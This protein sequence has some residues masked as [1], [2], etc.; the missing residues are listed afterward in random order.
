MLWTNERNG[1]KVMKIIHC[2]DLHLDSKMTAN[3]SKEQAKERKNEILRTFT[4]MVEYAKKNQVKVILIAGDLFDTRN[5]SAMV[6]NTVRDVIT[7]NPEIDFLY[8]KGN[9]DNDNF[10]SKLEEIPENLYLFGDEWTTYAY[11]NVRITGLELNAENSLTAYNSLVL[12]HDTFNIVTMHGQLSGY[13]N[14]DKTEIISL[15]DLKNKNIDYLALGHIHG[16]HMDKMD[17]RGIYCYP[18]CLEGRGFDECEQ[19]GFVVLD[20]NMDTLKANVNFVKMGYRTLYTMLVDVTGVS[21]TQEAA[22]RID[23]ALQENQYASSSLVKVVLYGEV[24][25]ECELDTSF[26]EEQFADYFYFIKVND[27]TKLLVNYKD[28]EGDVSLKGEFVRLVSESDLPEE[29]KSLVIRA[30]IL[31]LQ[32]EEINV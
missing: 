6:R 9:H 16:F 18:G 8:L 30:G 20:I 14:K 5:V 19:K 27:E 15:D 10:L 22:L 12:D 4:R 24:N 13:R 32:G 3:L 31:A 11:G 2:A 26:L 1:N 25:V 28:Y 29:E 7:Q 21:T 17:S 23:K